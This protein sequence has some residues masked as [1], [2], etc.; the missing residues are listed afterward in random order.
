[1]FAVMTKVMD[2]GVGV[3]PSPS[4]GK[5]I[6]QH[7]QQVVYRDRTTLPEVYGM[8]PFRNLPD[9]VRSRHYV[10]EVARKT[11]HSCRKVRAL[12]HPEGVLLR[13][14]QH[15]GVLQD[16]LPDAAVLPRRPDRRSP[17]CLFRIIRTPCVGQEPEAPDL[18]V[19]EF[20]RSSC[21]PSGGLGEVHQRQRTYPS[22]IGVAVSFDPAHWTAGVGMSNVVSTGYSISSGTPSLRCVLLG[23]AIP[24]SSP[25]QPFRVDRP[26]RFPTVR[27][28]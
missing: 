3:G 27:S 9:L 2:N 14:D 8:N 20:Q 11:V 4:T 5:I 12:E 23:V 26:L 17:G 7:G 25:A 6:I 1:M 24:P 10:A 15:R 21:Y 22:K 28:G 16:E 13:P 18:E 19:E